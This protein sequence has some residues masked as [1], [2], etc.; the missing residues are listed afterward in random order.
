MKQKAEWWQKVSLT[1]NINFIKKV[2]LTALKMQARYKQYFDLFTIYI[3]ASFAVAVAISRQTGQ[4]LYEI[5][6]ISK[7]FSRLDCREK[8]SAPIQSNTRPPD[9]KELRPLTLQ[10]YGG[11][12]K[13]WAPSYLTSDLQRY[14]SY[15]WNKLSKFFCSWFQF[16]DYYF[17]PSTHK[18]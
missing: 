15:H 18:Y 12:R 14:A 10:S 7:S 1:K 13:K 4:N 3:L 11:L 5:V 6:E 2:S 9:V 8:Y 16:S 17:H